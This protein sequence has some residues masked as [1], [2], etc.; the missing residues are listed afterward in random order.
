MRDGLGAR[1]GGREGL[2]RETEGQRMDHGRL[3]LGHIDNSKCRC[4]DSDEDGVD[5]SQDDD[6]TKS[7]WAREHLVI[8]RPRRICSGYMSP[9]RFGVLG[10]DQNHGMEVCWVWASQPGEDLRAA[11][12]V[13]RELASRRSDFVKGHGRSMHE[14]HFGPFY[15]EAKW[16]KE[17]TYG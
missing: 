7:R 6:C 5:Q 12:G 13:I 4:E 11:C 8:G 14:I 3:A 16:F 10:L 15:P 1:K 2:D 9:R 17:N